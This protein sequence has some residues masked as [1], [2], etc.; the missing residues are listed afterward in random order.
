MNKEELTKTLD[1]IISLYQ[2]LESAFDTSYRL[3]FVQIDGP[4]G[5]TIWQT[6]EGLLLV[7]EK[8]FDTD[9]IEWYIYE[10]NCGEKKMK[11]KSSNM[12]DVKEICNTKD[13]AQLILNEE[14]MH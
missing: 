2:N 3:G 7:I 6:F 4:F 13:L 11:A 10:N 5:N 9:W 12:K 1:T 14:E 8:Q